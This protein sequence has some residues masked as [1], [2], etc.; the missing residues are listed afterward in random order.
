MHCKKCGAS[1]ELTDAHCSQCGAKLKLGWKKPPA[2]IRLVMQIV[3]LLMCLT[4]IASLITT[5]L[6]A[7]IRRR[8][9]QRLKEWMAKKKA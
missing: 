4:L 8:N 5:V 9:D 3:S 1:I 7:D 2:L 6:L